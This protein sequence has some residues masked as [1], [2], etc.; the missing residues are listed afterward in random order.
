MVA[1]MNPLVPFGKGVCCELGLKVEKDD[2]SGVTHTLR[3]NVGGF[4]GERAEQ[5]SHAMG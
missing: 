4:H 5:R 3:L 2:F 1:S